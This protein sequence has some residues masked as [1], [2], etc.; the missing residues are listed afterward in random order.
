MHRRSCSYRYLFRKIV[1]ICRKTS[2]V[3]QIF[4]KPVGGKAYNSTETHST[5]WVF[6]KS[7]SVLIGT[8]FQ[9]IY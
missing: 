2:K 9:N 5:T 6:L 7:F 1:K 8:I 3:E 4:N